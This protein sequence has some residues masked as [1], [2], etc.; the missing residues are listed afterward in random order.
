M[1]RRIAIFAVLLLALLATAKSLAPAKNTEVTRNL[2]AWFEAHPTG[3]VYIQLD[4]PLYKPGETIWLK[5]SL[6]DTKNLAPYTEAVG[7]KLKLLEPSGA[8]VA[9]KA[10][11][12]KDG[13][14]AADI[15]IPATVAGGEYKIQV[16]CLGGPTEERPVVVHAYQAPLIQKELT[17]LGKAYGPGD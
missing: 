14:G 8:V 3:R 16:E 1:K 15:V 9:E 11:Q 7:Y 2:T 10:V 6:Y 4:K 13:S 17:V 12:M 5:A